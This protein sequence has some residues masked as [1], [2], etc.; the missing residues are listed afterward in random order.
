MLPNKRRGKG[1]GEIF[2]TFSEEKPF[3]EYIDITFIIKLATKEKGEKENS[4]TVKR[5]QL[6]RAVKSF[7]TLERPLVL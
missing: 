4:R 7:I 2:M 5:A 1:G 3:T 6:M